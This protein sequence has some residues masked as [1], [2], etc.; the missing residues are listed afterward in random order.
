MDT[1]LD[2][3]NADSRTSTNQTRVKYVWDQTAFG[4]GPGTFGYGL[5][6]TEAQINAGTATRGRW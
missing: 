1:G 5:E 6:F 3:A 2:L 4:P